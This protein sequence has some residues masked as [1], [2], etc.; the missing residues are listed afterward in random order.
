MKG[1]SYG[2]SEGHL[3]EGERDFSV[4][5]DQYFLQAILIYVSGTGTVSGMNSV[6]RPPLSE[7]CDGVLVVI[8]CI[9]LTFCST[10]VLLDFSWSGLD[11]VQGS[12]N[13]P[14]LFSEFSPEPTP[15]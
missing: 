5:E 15:K 12:D 6:C 10:S 2:T 8:S 3:P 13:F 7:V 11:Y 1:G 14:I 4:C 9:D